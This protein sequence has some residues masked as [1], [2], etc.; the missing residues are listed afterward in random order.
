MPTLIKWAQFTL[1]DRILYVAQASVALSENEAI[2]MKALIANAPAVV[3]KEQLFTALW[4]SSEFVDENIL[5]VNMTRL[6]KTV[7]KVGV[8]QS[9][10]T[11]RGVGYQLIGGETS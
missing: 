3:K 6:R 2:I 5:Q 1:V 8:S 7:E 9:I 10:K 11:V 4:G